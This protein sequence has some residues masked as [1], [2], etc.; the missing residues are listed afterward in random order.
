MHCLLSPGPKNTER[1]VSVLRGFGIDDSERHELTEGMTLFVLD[2][3]LIGA[4]E[5][6]V[7]ER[8]CWTTTLAPAVLEQYLNGV[9]RGSPPLL[10]FPSHF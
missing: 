5:R 8:F 2:D 9:R 7:L 10:S 6:A 4:D 3:G 1:V